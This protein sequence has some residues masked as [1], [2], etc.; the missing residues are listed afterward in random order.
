[1]DPVSDKPPVCVSDLVI[2]YNDCLES[3]FDDNRQPHGS[4]TSACV[5]DETIN[6]SPIL[7]RHF[8]PPDFPKS[9]DPHP[10]KFDTSLPYIPVYTHLVTHDL[11]PIERPQTPPFIKMLSLG[12]V[13]ESKNLVKSPVNSKAYESDDEDGKTIHLSGRSTKCF[14][15]KDTSSGIY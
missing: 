9:F 12:R 3:E 15:I 7:G 5:I 13:M 10:P 6:K 2:P 14:N 1:M 8:K 4:D 11:T